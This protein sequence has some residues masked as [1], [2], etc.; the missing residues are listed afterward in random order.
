[1]RISPTISRYASCGFANFEIGLPSVGVAQM[2]KRRVL[3]VARLHDDRD[4]AGFAAIV[5]LE[6]SVHLYVVAV[7]R[8]EEVGAHQEEHN[9]SAF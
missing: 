3:P 8:G 4:H 2:P 9:V 6:R 1:M 5:A 7:V